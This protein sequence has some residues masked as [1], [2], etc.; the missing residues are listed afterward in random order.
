MGK[1]KEMDREYKLK[2]LPVKIEKKGKKKNEGK[3][4]IYAS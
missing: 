3:N 4:W 1:E 2:T